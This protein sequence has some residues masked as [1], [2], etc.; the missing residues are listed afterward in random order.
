MH[1][2]SFLATLRRLIIFIVLFNFLQL[3]FLGLLILF[4]VRDHKAFTSHRL[5]EKECLNVLDEEVDNLEDHPHNA[6]CLGH[7]FKK[8]EC[9][10]PYC[11]DFWIEDIVHYE[12]LIIIDVCDLT[13]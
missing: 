4:L 10:P 6:S 11:S 7:Y 5:F 13:I 3:L 8:T 1:H 9:L 2:R 12:E